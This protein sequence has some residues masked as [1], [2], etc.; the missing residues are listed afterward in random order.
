MYISR[1]T[2]IT[3]VLSA[4]RFRLFYFLELALAAKQNAIP[5][6]GGGEL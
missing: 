3:D 4:R 6:A 2:K 1:P 5:D